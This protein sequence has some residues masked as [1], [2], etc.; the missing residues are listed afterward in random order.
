M[1]EEKGV[2]EDVSSPVTACLRR[3]VRTQRRHQTQR[4]GAVVR[5]GGSGVRRVTKTETKGNKNENKKG[6]ENLVLLKKE[7]KRRISCHHSRE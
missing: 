6:E 5:H 4:G 1:G 3:V 7:A 2:R